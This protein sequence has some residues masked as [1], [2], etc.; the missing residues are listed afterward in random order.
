MHQYIAAVAAAFVV[1]FCAPAPAL[2]ATTKP[3]TLIVA[4]EQPRTR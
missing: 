4:A 2:A 1:T 3:A